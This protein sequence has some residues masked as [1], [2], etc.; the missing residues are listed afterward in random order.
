MIKKCTI[1]DENAW[2]IDNQND[3]KCTIFD[4]NGWTIAHQNNKKMRDF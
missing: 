3:E 1:F 2:T 4:E